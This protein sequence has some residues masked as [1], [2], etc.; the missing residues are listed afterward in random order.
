MENLHTVDDVRHDDFINWDR[1]DVR[2]LNFQQDPSRLDIA[3]VVARKPYA[4][5][6][7]ESDTTLNVTNA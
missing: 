7:I 4:R 5:V 1:L 3:E 6:I 2:G